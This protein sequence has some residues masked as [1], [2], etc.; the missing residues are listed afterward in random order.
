MEGNVKTLCDLDRIQIPQELLT[1]SVDPQQ[2]EQQVDRLAIRFARQ[3][4]VEVAQL[5]DTVYCRADEKSYPDGRRILLYTALNIPGAEEAT[6]AVLGKRAGDTVSAVLAEKT[7]ELTVEKVIRP[8]P[9]VIDD[10]LI[11]Q[12]D[13]EG[14]A[15]VEDYRGYVTEKMKADLLMENHKAAVRY[16]LE[17]MLENSVFEYDEA[18][19]K[20]YLDEHMPQ[21]LAEYAS[22]GIEDVS[23]EEIAQGVLEQNK[24][25]WLAE[26]FCRQNGI[27]I[28]REAAQ[29]EARQMMEMM[30]LMGETV[31][32]REQMMEEAI[33]NAYAMELFQKIDEMIQQKMGR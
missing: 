33:R 31:P 17:Q 3:T 15:T 25:G 8:V 7:V 29:K 20:Q 9:V 22:Y 2:V 11:A 5:G 21:F 16:I 19:L 26:A 14:V 30:E 6:K 13:L 1:V 18:A 10:A 28:D 27:E 4:P 12:L 32:D 24:Q 23:E